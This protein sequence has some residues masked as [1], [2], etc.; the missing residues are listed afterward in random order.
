VVVTDDR[1]RQ[2]P[3][4][5]EQW[6]V[7]LPQGGGQVARRA[8]TAL[9]ADGRVWVS[10]DGETFDFPPQ[11]PAGRRARADRHETSEM[12]APMPATV[13]RLFV[14]AGDRVDAGQTV[15]ILEAMKMELPVRAPRDGTVA[16][17][18]CGVGD[19]VQPGRTLVDLAQEER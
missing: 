18:H 6:S 9:A 7:A 14:T 19:L 12:V 13:T 4:R 1:L 5:L 11:D 10:I 2:D 16:A 8:I 3:Q 15:L 17:V